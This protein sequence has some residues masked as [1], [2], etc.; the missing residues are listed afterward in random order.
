MPDIDGLQ[1]TSFI[2][3]QSEQKTIP[4]IMITSEQDS[5]RL[6]AIQHAGFSAILDKPFEPAS[7]RN[8]I[9]NLLN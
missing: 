1:L 4:I 6:A 5:Q 9:I 7:I 8:F 3:E 2:R